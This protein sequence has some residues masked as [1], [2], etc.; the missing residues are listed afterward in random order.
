MSTRRQDLISP[1][2][3]AAEFRALAKGELAR[4]KQSVTALARRV[5]RNRSTVSQA[6]HTGRFPRVRALI[7]Q[8]LGLPLS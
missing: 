7:A 5:R 8:E 1:S 6:I 4:R 3:A 2:D